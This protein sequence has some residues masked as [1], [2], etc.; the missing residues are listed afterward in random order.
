VLST[1]GLEP[2]GEGPEALAQ[3]IRTNVIQWQQVVRSAGL[4]PN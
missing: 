1:Q 2:A 4:N 3:T